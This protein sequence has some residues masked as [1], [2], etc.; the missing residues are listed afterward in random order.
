MDADGNGAE[1]GRREEEAVVLER[2]ANRRMLPDSTCENGQDWTLADQQ[3][4]P[5]EQAERMY[6]C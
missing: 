3:Q 1:D 5:A 2:S 6:T 4:V